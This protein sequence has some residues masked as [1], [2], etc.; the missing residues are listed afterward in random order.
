MFRLLARIVSSS[1]CCCQDI[2]FMRVQYE[3][4]VRTYVRTHVANLTRALD[5]Q[6]RGLESGEFR[7][8]WLNAK[9][10]NLK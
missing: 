6:H 9:S 4:C 10:S 2:L 5:T 3:T 8:C 1:C 7:E